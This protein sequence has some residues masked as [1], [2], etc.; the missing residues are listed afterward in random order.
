MIGTKNRVER[1]VSELAGGSLEPGTL[2]KIE[3]LEQVLGLSRDDQAFGWLVSGIRHKLYEIGLYLT[4]EGISETGGYEILHP[5]DNQWIGRLAIARA[6][7]DL[8]GKQTLLVNTKLDGLS[9]LEKRRHENVVREL[10]LKL[11][12]M[13]RAQ[14][15]SDMKGKHKRKRKDKEVVIVAEIVSSE[16]PQLPVE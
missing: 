7:R 8:E 16:L 1:A 12:A 15:F 14:D 2:I 11:T 4:G 9:D 10:S 5:R 6:E 3:V 13:R